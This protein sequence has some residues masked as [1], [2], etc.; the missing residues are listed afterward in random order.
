VYDEVDLSM[1]PMA[2]EDVRKRLDA[3]HK[4][5]EQII[6]LLETAS[7]AINVLQTGKTEA[8]SVKADASSTANS[9]QQFEQSA[10]DYFASLESISV[11]L[12]QEV[13][14]LHYESKEKVLPISLAAKAEWVG[15]NKE[16]QVWSHI[17]QTLAEASQKEDTVEDGDV[18]MAPI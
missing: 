1:A 4:L 3:L 10:K 17:K 9:K 14:M 7:T 6:K 13:R 15:Q 8:G 16:A 18:D 5:D 2:P 12:R 11:S